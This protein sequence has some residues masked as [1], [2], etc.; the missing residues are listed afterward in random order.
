MKPY[1]FGARNGIYIID[2]QKTVQ[3]FKKAYR[4][5]VEEV[6]EGGSVLFV[7]T[8]RQAAGTIRQ[9]AER[10]GMYWVNHRW[11]GGMLT[12]LITIRKSI[13]KLKHLNE[14]K[15]KEDW[16]H[17]TKKEIL[18]LEKMRIKLSRNLDGIMGMDKQPAAVF[19]IDPRRERIA[20]L[21]ARRLNIPIIGIVDTNCDPEMV[22]YPIPGNDDAIR[23]IK[24]FTGKI[25][26]AVQEGKRHF[27]DSVRAAKKRAPATE[28]A[29]Q[30]APL[31]SGKEL[32]AEFPK[33]IEIAVKSKPRKIDEEAEVSQG[34]K[35]EVEPEAAPEP[36]G[37]E[38][39]ASEDVA[40]Q[41]P[42]ENAL[43]EEQA[44]PESE[45]AGKTEDES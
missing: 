15:S 42:G 34:E 37:G 19:L 3:L 6:A 41:D 45:T 12:N 39:T 24:L 20:A 17:A 10:C 8:K 32:S 22:D 29:A 33:G 26:D 18:K 16:G 30:H 38:P 2:L 7:G 9:E 27:E 43:P 1:I 23:A 36:S 25:A 44:D 4:K 14:M 31:P 35:E 11:L 21:E 28:M 13:D 5:V 40:V